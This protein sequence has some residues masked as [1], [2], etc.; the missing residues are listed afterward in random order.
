MCHFLVVNL[1]SGEKGPVPSLFTAAIRK[2]YSVPGIKGP[3]RCDLL[4]G[5]MTILLIEE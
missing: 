1:T 4:R 3:S 2:R 5:F